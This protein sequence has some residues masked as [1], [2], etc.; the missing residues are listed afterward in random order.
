MDKVLKVFDNVPDFVDSKI[1]NEIIIAYF[2]FKKREQME[3]ALDVY[4]DKIKER[5]IVFSEE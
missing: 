1:R 3:S 4:L 2:M 5:K